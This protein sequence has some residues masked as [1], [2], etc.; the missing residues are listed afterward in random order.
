MK[1]KILVK[2][3]Q[4]PCYESFFLEKQKHLVANAFKDH[5]KALRIVNALNKGGAKADFVIVPESAAELN[6]IISKGLMMA[7]RIWHFSDIKPSKAKSEA[8]KRWR[9]IIDF[10]SVSNLRK[11]LHK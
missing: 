7:K 5:R 11:R 8:I 9:N 3:N 2:H 1:I 10:G 6:R 4:L